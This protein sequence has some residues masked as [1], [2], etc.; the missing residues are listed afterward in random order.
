MKKINFLARL[1]KEKKIQIVEPNQ[2]V[3]NAYLQ[4]SEESLRSARVLFDI[5]NLKDSVALTYY[6]MYYGLLALLFRVGIKCENHTGAILL[7]KQVFDIDNEQI[8]VAKKE[9]VDKQY[10]VDFTVSQNEVAK[11]ITIAEKFNSDLF[12]FIDKLNQQN[13]DE[14]RKKTIEILSA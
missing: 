6:S 4:R 1:Q 2:E 14:Y 9:R 11:M 5:N 10:Y 12:N 7:L 8:A 13:V 3:K